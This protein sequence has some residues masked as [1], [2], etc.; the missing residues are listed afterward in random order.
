MMDLK[1]KLYQQGW[2]FLDVNPDTGN[3]IYH[4]HRGNKIEIVLDNSEEKDEESGF[5]S[6][7]IGPGHILDLFRSIENENVEAIVSG[8]AGGIIGYILIPHSKR[9]I[10]ILNKN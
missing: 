8:K 3:E 6:Q 4:D 9:I 1:T 10:N 5:W 2:D 7:D